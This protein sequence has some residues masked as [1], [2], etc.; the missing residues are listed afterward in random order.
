MGCQ[1]STWVGCVQDKFPI[2]CN[3]SPPRVFVQTGFCGLL[4][5]GFG[6]LRTFLGNE[7][8]PTPPPPSSR[9]PGKTRLHTTRLQDQGND[10]RPNLPGKISRKKSLPGRKV[11]LLR[12]DK[13]KSQTQPSNCW[14]AALLAQLCTPKWGFRRTSS[15]LN[16]VPSC[17]RKATLVHI[18]P[19]TTSWDSGGPRDNMVSA[20]AA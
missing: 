19:T 20:D 16:L 13:K 9:T 2:L 1:K 7:E 17:W 14:G 10:P 5:L 11:S 12:G 15:P 6:F 18:H 3:S 8:Y 4:G